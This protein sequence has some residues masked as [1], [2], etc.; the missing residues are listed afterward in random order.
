MSPRLSP[1]PEAVYIIWESGGSPRRRA[2]FPGYKEAV[3]EVVPEVVPE[4]VIE[5]DPE[6]VSEAVIEVV[7]EAVSET[8]T[9]FKFLV[10]ITH[11]L[12][13]PHFF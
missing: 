1:K 11:F 6:A 8:E 4:A 13:L 2:I 3:I 5:A 7:S 10:Q 12:L 9:V